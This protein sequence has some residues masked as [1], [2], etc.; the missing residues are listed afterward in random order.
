MLTKEQILQTVDLTIEKVHVKEWKGDVYVRSLTGEERDRF[1]QSNLVKEGKSLE[2]RLFNVR[3]K[4]VALAM[5]DEHGNSILDEG[6]AVWLGGKS[7]GAIST[8]YDVAAR[9][10][11]ISKESIEELTKN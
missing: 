6:D 7:A 10:S 1:E 8:L 5:C 2:V 9:L 11:G 3:A 4:L